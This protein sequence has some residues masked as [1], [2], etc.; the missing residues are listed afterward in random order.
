MAEAGVVA[1]NLVIE[2]AIDDALPEAFSA[3]TASMDSRR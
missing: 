1:Q 3:F 2:P